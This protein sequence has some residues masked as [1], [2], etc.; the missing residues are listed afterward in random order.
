MKLPKA[1]PPKGFPAKEVKPSEM[2]SQSPSKDRL[3]KMAG[4]QPPVVSS[5][6]RNDLGTGGR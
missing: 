6:A 2:K 5:N 3:R 1:P 4:N